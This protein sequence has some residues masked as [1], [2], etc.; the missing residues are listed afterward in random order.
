MRNGS[1]QVDVAHTF[2]AHLGSRDLH[3]A[4]VADLA[5]ITDLLILA[6]VALPVLCRSKNLFAE[7]AVPLGLQGTVVDGL[8]FFHFAV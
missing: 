5:L 3:A 8:G 2:A 1:G 4:A 7:E 6:A